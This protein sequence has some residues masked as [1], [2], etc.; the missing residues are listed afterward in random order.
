M[1]NILLNELCFIL[2][3]KEYVLSVHDISYKCPK[4]E[5]QLHVLYIILRLKLIDE[6]RWQ[7]LS[8]KQN[9]L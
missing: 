7:Y 3:K 6:E 5:S 2:S 1:A 9:P 4:G 8:Y